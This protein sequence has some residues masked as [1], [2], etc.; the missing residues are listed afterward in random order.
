MSNRWTQI[1]RDLETLRR[2][3]AE[4][5][6][7]CADFH[8]YALNPPLAESDVV[9]F[10]IDQKISLPQ[11]YRE[12]LLLVGNG[13]AGPSYGVQRLGEMYDVPW[14]Q[15]PGIVG[16]LSKPFPYTEDWNYDPTT[17]NAIEETY[18]QQDFYWSGQHVIGAI[19]ICDHGCNLRDCLIVTGPERGNMWLDDRADWQGLYPTTMPNRNRITFF[20]WYRSW[21]DSRLANVP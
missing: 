2:L 8:K 17:S 19:P 16:E 11:D 21:L 9:H 20:E 18:R 15:M 5:V 12:F 6:L 1:L 3:D 13:G 14:S 7:P 4:F 10:E